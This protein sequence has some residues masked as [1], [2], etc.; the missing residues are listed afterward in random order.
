MAVQDYALTDL[1]TLK[2]WLS[3]TDSSSDTLLESAIDRASALIEAVCDR[4]LKSRTFYEWVMP[5]GER[6]FL[7]DN[8]P[9]LSVDLVAYGRHPSFTIASTTGSTDV[10]ATV[11][12]DGT[13]LRMRKVEAD[14]TS[15]LYTL[16]AVNHGSTSSLVVAINALTGWTATLSTNALTRSLYRTGGRSATNA[17]VV[18]DYA[19]DGA[20]IYEID[21]DLGRIHLTVDRF[22]G[23][24]ED[25]NRFPSGFNPVFVQYT[26]GFQTVPDDLEQ[27][28]LDVAADLYRERLNDKSVASEALG[29][30]N[31]SRRN[32][33]ELLNVYVGRLAP[34]REIR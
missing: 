2:A 12:F 13:S 24:G 33:E 8:P 27:V 14:G 31:Y 19:Y 22:P 11:G 26:G 5:R 20:S 30:Y 34:Y 23:S 32:A 21:Y 1:A 16:S 29:D 18:M 25:L 15:S 9:I 10:L 4:R 3:I 7:V 17:T 28:A 6:S